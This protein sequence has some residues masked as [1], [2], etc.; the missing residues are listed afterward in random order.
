[1]KDYKAILFSVENQIATIT[2]N[3]PES[4]NALTAVILTEIGEA[5]DVVE[6]DESIRVLVITGTGEKSFVAGANIKGFVEMDIDQ[7]TEFSKLGNDVCYKLSALRQPTIAAVNGYAL[8]GGTELALACDI[9]IAS[10][11]AI[12]GQPEVGLGI[13]P[14]FGGTQRLPKLIN[15]AIAKELIFTG[16]NV[17]ADEAKEIGLV[18]K[19]VPQVDLMDEVLYLA[20][21][22]TKQAPFAVEKS[23]QLIN[24]GLDMPITDG[25][26]MES[27]GFGSLFG[28]EDQK[29]GAKAFINKEKPTFKRQ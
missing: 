11:N 26:Q 6:A 17:R 22:I 8:G 7:G 28:T 27:E 20:N 25:I 19:V 18:N 16:R 14:G 23:K 4:L 2:I 9:R 12:F 13:P 15:P 21:Q 1:M 24:E 5:I 29:N 10:E 3:Q